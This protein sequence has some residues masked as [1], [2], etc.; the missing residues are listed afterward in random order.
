MAP[1]FRKRLCFFYWTYEN[2]A[3]RKNYIASE[4]DMINGTVGGGSEQT[5]Y[6]YWEWVYELSQGNF[7]VPEADGAKAHWSSDASEFQALY[8]ETA[9]E[10]QAAVEAHDE[11]DTSV[12]L[13][14]FDEALESENGTTYERSATPV[15]ISAITSPEITTADS[16]TLSAVQNAMGFKILFYGAQVA[17]IAG[18]PENP[19]EEYKAAHPSLFNG[20]GA[21]T[22]HAIS[23]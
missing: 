14:L 12:G 8:G 18:D 19:S 6:V 17:P 16:I 10:R 2:G 13:K 4:A 22:M 1:E 5:E 3:Y 11:W 15:T 20:Y 7:F 9:E 23:L 21:T